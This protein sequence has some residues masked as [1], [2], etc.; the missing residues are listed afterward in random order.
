MAS[1][2][3]YILKPQL[4][5]FRIHPV[6]FSLFQQLSQDF[7]HQRVNERLLQTVG[8]ILWRSLMIAPHAIE[9]GDEPVALSIQSQ[10][11][12]V[13]SLPWEC[14]YHPQWGFLGQYPAFSINR[15]FLPYQSF[16]PQNR[17][18]LQILWFAAQ[19]PSTYQRTLAVEEEQW[20]LWQSL[21]PWVQAGYVRLVTPM[22]GQFVN[23]CR[24][25]AGQSW[26]VVIV[27]GHGFE[28]GG[29][30]FLVF[31][32]DEE[33]VETISR[34]QLQV[35]L[36]Q[37]QI[38]CLIITACK[39]AWPFA[40]QLHQAGIPHVVGMREIVLD[41]AGERFVVHLCQA[42]VQGNRLD[43]A[44]QRARQAM[45]RLLQTDE[46][47]YSGLPR[48]VGQWSLPVLF[49]RQPTVVLG[50]WH[51]CL[52]AWQA[53]FT[54]NYQ[55]RRT[56]LVGRRQLVNKLVTKLQQ[57]GNYLCLWGTGGVG[58]TAL[59]K[60]VLWQL[61]RQGFD[62]WCW[63]L[64][65]NPQQAIAQWLAVKKKFTGGIVW[66]DNLTTQAQ[67]LQLEIFLARLESYS[68]LRV[69][70]LVT[71]RRLLTG[72]QRWQSYEIPS[73]TMLDFFR[74]AQQLGCDYSDL[75]LRFIYVALRGNYKGLQMLQQLSHS[76]KQIDL[77]QHLH[78]VQ[79]YLQ[80]Y[81]RQG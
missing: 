75:Q 79:R 28:Q 31:E 80:A 7:T 41:R 42:L 61:E 54:I 6:C 62:I 59:A 23:F 21:M 15:Q 60:K 2:P 38:Q 71:T 81:W 22:D 24:L 37:A 12:W 20:Q 56:L 44:L 27:T 10:L 58:K 5:Y 16:F 65:I 64:S 63:P 29:E 74:Y 9:P 73:P 52:R 55:Q 77:K 14:L 18:P 50:R 19:P 35:Q 26:D 47:W 4:D 17:R 11:P 3:H 57:G 30:H 8:K 49:S 76:T 70:A 66:G 69:Q 36:Q 13:H 40:L 43:V 48:V 46:T 78:V 39:S 51:S 33:C 34:A 32:K 1:F 45:R 68:G 53:V 25:L 72:L 67:L